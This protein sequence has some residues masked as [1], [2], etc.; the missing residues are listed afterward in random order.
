MKTK[1]YAATSSS[2]PLQPFEFERRSPKPDDVVIEIAYCG[3][4]HSDIHTARSEWGA[5]MY[6]CVPGH[7]IVGRVIQVGKKVNASKLA[8]TQE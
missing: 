1:A 6:P 4:C 7:E 3:I 5:T 8:I 2:S